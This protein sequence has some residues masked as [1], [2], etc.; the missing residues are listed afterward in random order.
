MASG[1]LPPPRVATPSPAPDLPGSRDQRAHTAVPS[2]QDA[3]NYPTLDVAPPAYQERATAEPHALTTPSW[4]DVTNN[5][6][7]TGARNGIADLYY[8]SGRAWGYHKFEHFHENF[9][10]EDSMSEGGFQHV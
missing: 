5:L 8:P 7:A 2:R 1:S 4:A 10:G 9:T 6:A 3:H